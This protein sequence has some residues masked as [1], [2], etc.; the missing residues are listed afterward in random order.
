MRIIALKA[1]ACAAV[2][3]CGT[4]RAVD[5]RRDVVSG[6]DVVAQPAA[7]HH[8]GSGQGEAHLA[9]A[10]RYTRIGDHFVGRCELD[11]AR[12]AIERALEIYERFL[13]SSEVGYAEALGARSHLRKQLQDGA[14]AARDLSHSIDILSRHQREALPALLGA[15]AELVSVYGTTGHN[16][17]ARNAVDRSI[18][19]ALRGTFPRGGKPSEFAA[20]YD[21]VVV[22]ADRY[23]KVGDP[24]SVAAWDAK[25][26]VSRWSM[27]DPWDGESPR[28][29]LSGS[30]NSRSCLISATA[31]GNMPDVESVVGGLR[32]HFRA[33]YE[34]AL[35][36]NP[37]SQ[38]A[39]RV[40]ARVALD[41]QVL[42][43]RGVGIGLGSDTYEC[44]TR[45]VLAAHFAP[46]RGGSTVVAIPVT[47]V[48]E[49]GISA[50]HE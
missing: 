29:G 36:K 46:P 44:I 31:E 48:Q 20:G 19:L 30:P 40:T 10:W 45:A 6:G 22:L 12:Q 8:A 21:G 14:G 5:S 41:G 42:S 1:L 7:G 33:C 25:L 23:A 34:K 4:T 43:S 32:A 2:V 15:Y 47:L 11:A 9:A 24:V 13:P 17:E 49:P 26:N 38:G 37:D 39:L 50:D 18:G 27:G 35:V 16:Q 28:D 3:S